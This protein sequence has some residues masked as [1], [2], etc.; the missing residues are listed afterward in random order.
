MIVLASLSHL[1]AW[2]SPPLLTI[3][4]MFHLFAEPAS[5]AHSRWPASHSLWF[6]S[7]TQPGSPTFSSG[8]GSPGRSYGSRSF[9]CSSQC[10]SL[11]RRMKAFTSVRWSSHSY[12]DFPGWSASCSSSSCCGT[13]QSSLRADPCQSSRV[14]LSLMEIAPTLP[15]V[16][17]FVVS[18]PRRIEWTGF[19]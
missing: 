15:S 10:V 7:L 17:A 9:A 4:P 19:V 11:S 1:L 12:C 14:R 5:P 3:R 8:F 2:L 13:L 6:G 16:A 18:S